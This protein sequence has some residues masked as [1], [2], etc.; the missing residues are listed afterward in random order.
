[1][2]HR[3]KRTKTKVYRKQDKNQSRNRKR[4]GGRKQKKHL[5]PYIITDLLRFAPQQFCKK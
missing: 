2:N 4:T 3:K 1:V 5:G